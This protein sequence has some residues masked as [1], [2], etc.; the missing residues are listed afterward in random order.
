MTIVATLDSSVLYPTPLSDVLT[1]AAEA[2]L[3][4]PHFSQ[5]ILDN[6]VNSLVR[7]ERIS[8][9]TAQSIVN[10]FVESF[11]EALQAVHPKQHEIM[12]NHP[13][14]RHV[15]AAAYASHSDLV[16]TFHLDHFK[17]EHLEPWGIRAVHPDT[18][19]CDLC[20]EVGNRKVFRII[21][22]LVEDLDDPKIS[23]V[24]LLDKL[25]RK[26]ITEFSSRMA[27]HC[28]TKDIARIATETLRKVKHFNGETYSFESVNGKLHIATNEGRVLFRSLPGHRTEVRII[29]E[30]VRQFLD[31]E[32]K[33]KALLK[34]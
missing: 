20:D 7:K 33:S 12:D 8:Q 4:R 32:Q 23:V 31:F 14:D 5:K 2:Y 10:E 6:T 18:F 28:F 16:I 3:F 15:L 34:K 27:T 13:S 22:K 11:P 1:Y 24:E 19:L 26:Q 30:D 25:Y 29:P 21:E 9:K 17:A